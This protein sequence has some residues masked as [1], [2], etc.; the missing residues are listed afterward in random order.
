MALVG[1]D[2][3]TAKLAGMAEQAARGRQVKVGFLEGA[4]YPDGTPVA[5]VA[6][7]N[8][9][10]TGRSPSRPFFRTM[11][12]RRKPTWGREL[13]AIL[14]A[15]QLD[16]AKA[17][18]LLGQRVEEQLRASISTGNWAPNAPATIAAK[19]AG[20]AP[21]FDTKVMFRAVGHEVEG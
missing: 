6:A 18:D 16:G 20:K 3:L 21:L 5:T 17:L 2:K 4:T 13:A 14:K 15:V 8:E 9:Y 11:I 19:G 12:T 7:W 1:G 10:G